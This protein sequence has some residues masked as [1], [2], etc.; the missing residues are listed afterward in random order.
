LKNLGPA[1]PVRT[2]GFFIILTVT[3]GFLR[4]LLIAAS[5]TSIES[6]L[7]EISVMPAS[8][9]DLFSGHA[10][11]YA[12][13]RPLYPKDLYD[14]ILQI[15]NNR[16]AAL[17]CGTGNGQCA[18][19]LADHFD[20]VSAT[21]ISKNQ[22]NRAI[23]KS[24]LHYYVCN[25]EHT[26]FGGDV[27]DL[28]TVATAMHW[29]RFGEFFKEIR[30]VGK[31]GCVFACWAYNI[32]TTENPDLNKMID[33]FYRHTIHDYWDVERKHVDTEYRNIPFPF[34]EI[35]NPGFATNVDWDFTELEGYLNTWSAVQHYLSSHSENPVTELIDKMRR[36]HPVEGK[37]KMTF[38]IFMR[39]GIIRK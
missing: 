11:I 12:K 15:V 16:G 9:K 5:I 23:Q 31:N 24:N 32:V 34:D 25:A 28:V 7:Y 6:L 22:I 8:S 18:G 10:D 33:D 39:I 27:F 17:D 29:F 2:R 19:V 38:P 1:V 3:T 26:P 14:F 4:S 30:R 37:L 20:E 35:P 21:D 13:Y 36:K